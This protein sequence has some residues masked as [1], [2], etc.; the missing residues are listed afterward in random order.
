MRDNRGLSAVPYLSGFIW[1][2]LLMALAIFGNLLP[3]CFRLFELATH[4]HAIWDVSLSKGKMAKHMLVLFS[5]LKHHLI[6]YSNYTHFCL[7]REKHLTLFR[8]WFVFSSLLW[9]IKSFIDTNIFCSSL[10]LTASSRNRARQY[11]AHYSRRVCSAAWQQVSCMCFI[12][13]DTTV[14]VRIRMRIRM[15]VR[16][17]VCVL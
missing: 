15:R 7:Y 16:V 8:C 9:V 4:C 17:L 2:A 11:T 10:E 13:Q 14:S 1:M 12:Q 3:L 5:Y 6:G